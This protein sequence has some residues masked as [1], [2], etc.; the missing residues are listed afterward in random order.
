MV[1]YFAYGSN[2]LTERL[3]NRVPS[4]RPISSVILSGYD[5]RW[6]KSST[7]GSGKCDITRSPAKMVHGVLFEM[8]DAHLG[9]LDAAEGLGHGYH[10]HW[11]AVQ[12]ING[13]S[14]LALSYAADQSQIDPIL[15]PYDWYHSLVV[16]GARHHSL[17]DEYISKLGAVKLSED[18]D[19][20]RQVRL[21]A[22][23]ILRGIGTGSQQ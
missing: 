21:K 9:K 22:V 5:L 3:R 7:D 8:N 18:I 15:K 11:V 16:D 17:P 10:H 4:V 23:E 20:N 13:A 14:V 6:H 1:F 12:Q 2:M 19:K